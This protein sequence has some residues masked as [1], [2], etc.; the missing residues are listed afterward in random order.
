M[1]TAFTPLQ[2]ANYFIKK[3]FDTGKGLTPMKL[4]KLC[5]VAHGWHLGITGEPL[6]TEPI[7]AWKYGPVIVSLYHDFKRYGNGEITSLEA[8]LN[9]EWE[10][11]IPMPNDKNIESL[12]DK[13][14]EIYGK[15]DGVFL[16]S[17][18]HE[19]GTPWDIVW[20][21][22]G[23]SQREGA[24]IPNDLIREHYVDK[25]NRTNVGE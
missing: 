6:L 17:L 7:Q 16:S 21:R 3:N 9:D 24:I 22:N 14:W 10:S 18:T 19:L 12:L 13:I 2:V 15:Y 5:Y 11:C 20:N 8:E 23:G 4:L 1:F 25:I